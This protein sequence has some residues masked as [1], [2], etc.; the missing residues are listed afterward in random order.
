VPTTL[1]E[2]SHGMDDH[3]DVLRIRLRTAARTTALLSEFR[4]AD[5][6]LASWAS[7]ADCAPVEFEVTFCDG[8]VVR[9]CYAFFKN[10]KLRRSLSVHVRR[11]LRGPVRVA[12]PMA[13]APKPLSAR[14]LVPL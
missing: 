5:R 2:T 10:G 13:P 14:Y 9:G 4:C 3:V 12:D 1:P 8:H 7:H 6:L 11:E